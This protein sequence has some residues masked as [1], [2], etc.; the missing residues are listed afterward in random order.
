[1]QNQLQISEP[2]Q[3]L[4]LDLLRAERDELPTEIH[5]TDNPDMGDQLKQRMDLVDGL[6]N[7]LQASARHPA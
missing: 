6:I 4:I 7:R 2:E 3:R 1:V 5:H